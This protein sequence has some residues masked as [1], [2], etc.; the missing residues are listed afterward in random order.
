MKIRL[1]LFLFIGLGYTSVAFGQ[2]GTL[3]YGFKAGLTLSKFDGPSE[4]A[5]GQDLEI[6]DNANGFLVGAIFRYWLT[7]LVGLKGEILYSQRGTDY[8][9]SG[10]GYQILP[11]V[12]G[13]QLFLTGNQQI[14][15]N[16]SN[17]YLDFPILAYGK[18]GRFEIEGG[19]NVGLLVSTT[20][21]GSLNF[22]AGESLAGNPV[23]NFV[24]SLDYRYRRDEPGEADFE[25]GVINLNVDGSSQS[26]PTILNA[27]SSFSEDRGNY[28]NLLDFGLNAGAY[29]YWNQGLFLGARFMYGLTDATSDDYDVSRAELDSNQNFIPRSD[30]DRNMSLQFSLGFSF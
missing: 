7:D 17:S 12:A 14:N 8:N 10:A 5:N 2:A 27:Y 24:T 16:I 4:Q 30:K 6:N 29:Y 9:F 21:S 3:S 28:F 11:T 1:L 26:I 19:I 25:V 23:E 18:F 20:A 15:L 22:S 13:S